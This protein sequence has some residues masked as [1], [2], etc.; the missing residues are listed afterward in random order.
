MPAAGGDG[1]VTS[2]PEW[3]TVLMTFVIVLT[4]FV[5]W[6][7]AVAPYGSPDENDH[8]R[9]AVAV[10]SGT[11]VVAVPTDEPWSSEVAE[12]LANRGVFERSELS[13]GWGIAEI[14]AFY[15]Q[16]T[17][18]CFAFQKD[19][20]AECQ[21]FQAPPGTAE[22]VTAARLYPK[23]YYA[24]VGL[25]SLVADR[26]ATLYAMRIVSGMLAAGRR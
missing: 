13:V 16:D 14:P 25:P 11:P 22:A 10:V 9:Y 20:T 19:V 24:L 18:G 2:L 15:A 26:P 6:A 21:V 12:Q 1:R 4:P 5:A 8:V 3:L 17:W 23:A 7:L